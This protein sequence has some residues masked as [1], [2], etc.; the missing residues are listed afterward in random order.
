M[1]RRP[2]ALALRDW[3]GCTLRRR[4]EAFPTQVKYELVYQVFDRRAAHLGA[5]DEL[6]YA[7]ENW[8]ECGK[9]DFRGNSVVIPDLKPK[10]AYVFRVRA[11]TLDGYS[12]Y[13]DPSEKMVCAR[14]Y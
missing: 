4:R 3:P 13:T 6:L 1:T 7:V 14:R 12:V 10:E 9:D 11:L 8:K 5:P 2:G